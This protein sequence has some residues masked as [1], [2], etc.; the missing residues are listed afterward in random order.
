MGTLIGVAAAII[1]K[2]LFGWVTRKVLNN[3]PPMTFEEVHETVLGKP[4][5][6]EDRVALE[7]FKASQSRKSAVA[8]RFR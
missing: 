5:T 8:N 4:L 2:E 7:R 6:E 1:G 3:L